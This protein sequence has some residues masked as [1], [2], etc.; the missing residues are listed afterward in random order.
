MSPRTGRGWPRA[1]SSICYPDMAHAYAV[2]VWRIYYSEAAF[3]RNRRPVQWLKPYNSVYSMGRGGA[4]ATG[5]A[6]IRPRRRLARTVVLKPHS[7]LPHTVLRLFPPRLVWH[8]RDE[9]SLSLDIPSGIA[10]TARG[11]SAMPPMLC[12]TGTY[13]TGR[14]RTDSVV[15]TKLKRI[16]G[17]RRHAYP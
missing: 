8:D 11:V 10:R 14:K 4:G 1:H 3:N 2:V 12:E 15:I 13:A 9:F 5:T 7:P 16:G 17:K 6:L